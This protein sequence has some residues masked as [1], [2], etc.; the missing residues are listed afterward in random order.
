M[1]MDR[2]TEKLNLLAMTACPIDWR[3]GGRCMLEDDDLYSESS[4]ATCRAC[5]LKWLSEESEDTH[6]E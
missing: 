6:E 4:I 5:W 1:I 3:S 2:N